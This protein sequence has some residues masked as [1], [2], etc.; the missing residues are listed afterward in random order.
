M[1]IFKRA[2]FFTYCLFLITLLSSCYKKDVQVG[3]DLAESHTRLITVDTVGVVLSSYVLDS[4]ATS[5]N[6]FALIGKYIDAY[7]GTTVASTF[8]Q[9]GLP[10]LSED[11]STLL[12]K[13]AVPDSLMLYMKPSGYY[14]GDTTKSFDISVYELAAQPDYTNTNAQKLYNTSN[15]PV[16]AS[17]LTAWSQVISPTRRDSIKI[18]LPAGMSTDFFTRIQQKATQFTSETNFLDYFKGLSI[19]PSAGNAAVYGFN[20]ADSSVRIRLHYH[21]TIPYRTDKYIDFILTRTSYQFNRIITDRN[22]TALAPTVTGQYEFFANT[23]NPFSITQSGTGVLLKAKFPSLRD[24]L[25]IDDVVKLMS[26]KLILEPVKGTYSQYVNK[27][28]D[29][30][31]M[32]TTDNTNNFGSALTD[33]TGSGIQYQSPVIDYVYGF[34]SSYTFSITSYVNYLMNTSGTTESGMF[35]L[36]SDPTTAKQIDRGVIGSLQNNDYQVK[37]VLTLLTIE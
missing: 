36:Q 6:S 35:I 4:F 15:V 28:P 25:K 30:L 33:P 34:N 3:A 5:G 32:I 7:T 31:F 16:N 10:T 24:V 9:P 26:A 11:A 13:N 37:L 22:N 19:V 21:L 14:Y 18:K 1:Y 17:P 23:T 27:L 2:P 12:P 29:P 20:L 8:L